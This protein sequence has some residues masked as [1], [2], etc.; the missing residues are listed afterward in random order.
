MV[1]KEYKVLLSKDQ[2][3][4]IL[5]S[6]DFGHCYTQINFY[7]KSKYD[8]E[9]DTTIRVRSKKEQMYLQV[10]E[11]ISKRNG[12]HV[13]N[14]YQME[15]SEVPYL[16]PGYVLNN[17][18]KTDKYQDAYLIGELITERRVA[19]VEKDKIAIDVNHY[20]GHIDYELEIEFDKELDPEI[21]RVLIIEKIYNEN[22]SEGKFVRFYKRKLEMEKAAD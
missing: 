2:Y 15:L 4:N 18:C 11:P 16:I 6:F 8:G 5:N 7:Y 13:K 12:V 19:R 3:K 22:N 10:K 9:L 14:E 17:L 20:L 21:L 1:E